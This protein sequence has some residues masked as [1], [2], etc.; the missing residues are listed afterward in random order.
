MK[1]L[2]PL[3]FLSFFTAV[4]TYAQL[5]VFNLQAEVVNQNS[6]NLVWDVNTPAETDFFN[7]YRSTD[8][9]FVCDHTTWIDSTALTTYSEGDLLTGRTFHYRVTAVGTDQTESDPSDMAQAEI[10]AESTILPGIVQDFN[11]G[12]IYGWVAH[13]ATYSLSNEENTFKIDYNR[14][15]SSYEWTQCQYVL[16]TEVDPSGDPSIKMSYRSD[17]DIT[18]G[19]KAIYANGNDDWMQQEI[20]GDNQWNDLVFNLS[21]YTGTTITTLYFYFDGGSNQ[22]K[23]GI[24]YFDDIIIGAEKILLVVND[25]QGVV[26]DSNNVDLAWSINFPAETKTFHVYRGDSADFPCVPAHLVKAVEKTSFSERDL[27]I[28]HTYYYKVTAENFNGVEFEPAGPVKIRTFRSTGELFVDVESVNSETPGLYE[29]H[30]IDVILL[31]ADYDNP[32]DPDQLDLSA[33]F[34]SPTGKV[35]EING[36]Y[37]N[38]NNV[39]QWKIRFSPNETGEWRYTLKVIDR[40]DTATTSE[41]TLNAV[42]SN[43]KGWIRVSE[44]NPHYFEYDNGSSFYGVGAYYPWPQGDVVAMLDRLQATGSNFWALMNMPYDNGT[45]FES[46]KSGLGRYDQLQCG[47]MEHLLE[48]SEERDLKMQY[49]IW[50]HR[51]IAKDIW[52]MG[53]WDTRNPYSTIMNATEFF[54]HEE[55]WEYQKKQFRYLIARYAGYRSF[56]IWELVNEITG[57]DAWELGGGKHGS[58]LAWVKKMDDYFQENDPYNHPTTASQHGGHYWPEGYAEV[59]VSNVHLYDKGWPM[60]YPSNVV[61]S[62]LY[63]YAKITA[64]MWSDNKQPAYMGEAGFMEQ[65]SYIAP[66]SAEYTQYYHNALW[67]CWANGSA[68]TPLWWE[69]NEHDIMYDDVL[70]QLTAFGKVYGLIDYTR[71]PLKPVEASSLSADAYAMFGDSTGFGWLREINGDDVRGTEITITGVP[72]TTYRIEW[73]RTWTGAYHKETFSKAV[74]GILTITVPSSGFLEVADKAFIIKMTDEDHTAVD[75]SRTN[76]SNMFHL[77]QNY[78]NPCYTTTNIEFSI[79]YASIVSLKVYD[80]SGREVATVVDGI[81]SAGTYTSS[82]DTGQLKRGIYLYTLKSGEFSQTRKIILVK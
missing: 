60:R 7:I 64:D 22:T 6:V 15:A 61:R 4:A 5:Q 25:F 10:V 55:G 76:T 67:G 27:L 46:D 16:P 41:Y 13:D 39:N 52:D 36:Y 45:I 66:P 74:D 62:G 33:Q 30:E 75:E 53:F 9:A 2:T 21:K 24:V 23:S 80:V 1:K 47:W 42:E 59:D 81:R 11:D 58:G 40:V 65:H 3:L 73:Y 32:Y 35:W 17:T 57:T 18:F 54:V 29:R 69:F 50:V 37:D 19:V 72:D 38:Y 48:L 34:T 49:A 51:V 77:G 63:N 79:P 14:T 20:T 12:S 8:P 28:N 43:H 71:E 82:F 44:K 68:S 56:A 78:P 31:D 26:A 70:E